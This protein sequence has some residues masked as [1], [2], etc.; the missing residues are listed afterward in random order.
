MSDELKPGQRVRVTVR[1]RM[2]GYQPGDK[3][4]VLRSSA[5]DT[6]GERYYSVAMDKDD[7]TASGAVFTESEIEPDV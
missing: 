2:A 7:P 4:T 3:G 6:T 5:S 1:N